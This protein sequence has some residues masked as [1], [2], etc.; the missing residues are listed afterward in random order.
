M[1]TV[2]NAILEVLKIS[3]RPTRPIAKK[4]N[5]QLSFSI[6]LVKFDE[7]NKIKFIK[8]HRLDQGWNPSSL[9]YESGTLTITL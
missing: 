1:A 9:A 8:N 4:Q 7:F 5:N 2:N 6:I 3:A